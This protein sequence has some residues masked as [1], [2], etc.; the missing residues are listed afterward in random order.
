[1]IIIGDVPASFMV[2][3]SS[4][5][6]WSSPAFL[7]KAVFL[8]NL[9]HIASTL[10]GAPVGHASN[11]FFPC[12]LTP[13]IVKSMSTS[14]NAVTSY[15]L[16][17]LLSLLISYAVPFAAFLCAAFFGAADIFRAALRTG[18]CSFFLFPKVF[19]AFLPAL[20]A[21][22]TGDAADITGVSTAL[23]PK[24]FSMDQSIGYFFSGREQNALECRS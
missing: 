18:A 9:L 13:F 4:L 20:I 24:H 16:S 1:M 3:F 5:P 21:V 17:L 6:N 7:I 22:F 8:S 2:F 14:P 12:P 11:I 23:D 10:Q 15:I 19:I